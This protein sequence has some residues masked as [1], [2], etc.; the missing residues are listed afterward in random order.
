MNWSILKR[1][2][3]IH[4]PPHR[5]QIDNFCWP[6]V[7]VVNAVKKR[8]ERKKET[9]TAIQEKKRRTRTLINIF[10]YETIISQPR[11]QLVKFI[12]DR[13]IFCI[14]CCSC[15]VVVVV[16]ARCSQWVF[17][18]PIIWQFAAIVSYH[19]NYYFN[20]YSIVNGDQVITAVAELL[21]RRIRFVVVFCFVCL[22][23][24]RRF[25]HI[26]KCLC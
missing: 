26:V 18:N 20:F 14:C 25:S 9:Q 13:R 4:S 5:M 2:N 21:Q 3:W 22:C 6:G 19:W 1:K 16:L 24:A 11:F 8:K 12:F 23:L 7:H 15:M 17:S 10:I